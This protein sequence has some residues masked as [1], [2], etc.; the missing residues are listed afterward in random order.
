MVNFLKR[1]S[2][3][4]TRFGR[5]R[6]VSAVIA[7]LIMVSITLAIGFALWTSVNS[8]AGTTLQ[9]H[10]NQTA[11]NVNEIREDFVITVIAFEQPSPGEVTIWFYNNGGLQTDIHQVFFGNN[12]ASLS[13][14]TFSPDPLTL[15]VHQSGSIT[16]TYTTNS[17]ETYYAKVVAKYGN[18]AFSY[19][20]R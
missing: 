13:P 17:G 8:T 16:F 7:N 14:V 12:S 1:R 2:S 18:T 11:S 6:A 9:G 3:G 19:E 15:A 5:K 10:A 4:R 20:G